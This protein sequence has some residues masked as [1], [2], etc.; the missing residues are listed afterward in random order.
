MAKK[1][2]KKQPE[3]ITITVK[4]AVAK[5][6]LESLRAEYRNRPDTATKETGLLFWAALDGKSPV[7]KISLE[8]ETERLMDV[9]V[10]LL[11]DKASKS[12]YAAALLNQE[13]HRA[14]GRRDRA[15]DNTKASE[16]VESVEELKI[17]S[18]LTKRSV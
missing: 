3:V 6:V 13:I 9:I 8:I 11:R 7:E 14:N 4:H 5:L 2:K 17:E 16:T 10:I 15:A 1:R 18:E 12:Q